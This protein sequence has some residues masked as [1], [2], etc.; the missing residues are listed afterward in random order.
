MRLFEYEVTLR[1]GHFDGLALYSLFSEINTRC[2]RFWND[3]RKF[4]SELIILVWI[5]NCILKVVKDVPNIPTSEQQ[6]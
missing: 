1:I 4:C 2:L 5:A 6:F 3:S